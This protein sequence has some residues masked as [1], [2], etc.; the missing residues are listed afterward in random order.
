MVL[1]LADRFSLRL[2]PI[3]DDGKADRS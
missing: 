3:T 2:H 1:D